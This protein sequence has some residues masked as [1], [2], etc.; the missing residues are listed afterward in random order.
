MV[1][2]QFMLVPQ[3]SLVVLSQK[4]QRDLPSF[5]PSI[6]CDED[7]SGDD[8][9]GGIMFVPSKDEDDEILPNTP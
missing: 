8:H 9:Q 1:G 3:I 4:R 2:I 7:G 6:I 5:H